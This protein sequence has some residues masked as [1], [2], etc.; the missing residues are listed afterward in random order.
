M[1]YL[2]AFGMDGTA[3][4]SN[5]GNFSL[6]GL[7]AGTVI[8]NIGHTGYSFGDH[9]D[10]RTF[11]NGKLV[12]PLK[13]TLYGDYLSNKTTITYEARKLSGYTTGTMDDIFYKNV[14]DYFYNYKDT[15]FIWNFYNK[16]GIK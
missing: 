15:N 6:T 8:G 5:S 3:I 12:N 16:W 7:T 13:S 11:E 14:K 2:A 4:K 9:L 1:N 10:W